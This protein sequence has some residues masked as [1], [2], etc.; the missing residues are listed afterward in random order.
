MQTFAYD[1]AGT[2]T[3]V[4][5]EDVRDSARYLYDKLRDLAISYETGPEFKP[6]EEEYGDGEVMVIEDE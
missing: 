2:S 4:E 3:T 1:K 6:V 5:I